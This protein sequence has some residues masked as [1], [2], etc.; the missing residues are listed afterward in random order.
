[1]G[2]Q[3]KEHVL[4]HTLIT[5]RDTKTRHQYYYTDS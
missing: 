3:T 4:K 5:N 1:M 2:T